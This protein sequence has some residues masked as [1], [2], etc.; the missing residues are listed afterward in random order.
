[1]QLDAALFLKY[2]TIGLFNTMIAL[3]HHSV[4]RQLL[5]ADVT[6][7]AHQQTTDRQ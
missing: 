1:M 7:E 6:Q 5:F 2:L 3:S 4:T